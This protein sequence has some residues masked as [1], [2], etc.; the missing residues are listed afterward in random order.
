M[1][2]SGNYITESDVSNWDVAVSDTNTF[3]TTDV[4][5]SLDTIVAGIDIATGSIIKFTSTEVLPDPLVY[6]QVYYAIRVDATTIKVAASAVNAAAGTAIDITDT[7]SGT[8]TVDVGEGESTTDRQEVI[9]RAELLIES[10]TRD[11]FYAAS[12][13]ATLDGNG[14]DRLCLGRVASVLSVTSVELCG[15]ELSSTYYRC[16]GTFI[17]LNPIVAE[18]TELAE[19]H[20]RLRQK[21]VLFPEGMG[22]VVVTGTEGW[23]SCPAAIKKA[24][25]ILCEYEND[26]TL[27]QGYSPTDK[28]ES[29]DGYSRSRNER[30]YMTGVIEA[31]RLLMQYIKKKRPIIGMA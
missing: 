21:E 16:D 25:I 8:H 5:A 20:L 13:E 24:A 18:V 9:N 2:A 15:V 30:K 11:Y 31:D 28:S 23:S 4:D 1:P 12:F 17:Y 3:S 14:Q 26:S 27:Y 6:G 29:I 19:L 10:V 7:G 22:N